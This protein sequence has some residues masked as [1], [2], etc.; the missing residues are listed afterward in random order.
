ML[1]NSTLSPRPR[2]YEVVNFQFG[3]RAVDHDRHHSPPVTNFS[4]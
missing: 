2:G 1:T 3:V 4:N